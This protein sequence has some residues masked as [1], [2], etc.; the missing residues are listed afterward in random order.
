MQID[1]N[2]SMKV[3]FGSRNHNKTYSKEFSSTGALFRVLGPQNTPKTGLYRPQ[4]TKNDH[5][6]KK[7]HKL[8]KTLVQRF[9]LVPVLTVE[10]IPKNLAPQ[11]HSSGF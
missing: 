11:E 9:Y 8:I 1:Q 3:L 6:H 7:N 2:T 4:M 10:H 5:P